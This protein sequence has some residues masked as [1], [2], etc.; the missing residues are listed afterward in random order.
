MQRIFVV[1]SVM[2]R[3]FTQRL[4]KAA[5]LAALLLSSSAAHA[6]TPLRDCSTTIF[7]D[8]SNT[9][10][11]Q[12]DMD[13]LNRFVAEC[14]RISGRTVTAVGYHLGA[15]TA[16]ANMKVSRLRAEAVREYLLT[17]DLHATAIDVQAT[18]DTEVG[19]P[20]AQMEEVLQAHWRK[21]VVHA[22]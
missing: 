10:L 6:V 21:V 1:R 14:R 17:L 4:S 7:F 13:R 19:K 2:C 3:R 9:R 18:G 22:Y 8:G 12:W 16:E 20:P 15:E 11:S 5:F